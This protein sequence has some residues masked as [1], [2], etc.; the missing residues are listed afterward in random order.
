MD[1]NI[2]LDNFEGP[3]D[4]LLK[5]IDKSKI[6]IYDIPISDIT[7]QYMD[8]IYKM[9]D[10]NLELASEFLI[11]ASILL[12]IKSKMLLPLEIDLDEEEIDPREDLVLRLLAYKKYKEAARELREYETIEAQ[13]FYKPQEDLTLEEDIDYQLDFFSLHLL[14][15]SLNNILNRKNLTE[16][17]MNIGEIT[18][19]EY[20]IRECVDH[21]LEKLKLQSKIKF[22]ELL[23]EH[24]S[25]NEIVA[26]FLSV[27][28]L[29]KQKHIYVIQ[30]EA[31]TDLLI[32]KRNIE[33]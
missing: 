23:R 9:E 18:R 5:L 7:E 11:M 6:D 8:F 25:R 24:S 27:L 2:V 29:I 10:L 20:S 17:E 1:Y 4:L 32:N 16:K 12:E 15:R 19:D 22:T 21:I 33:E 13:A 31:F 26:Y 30:D 3:L 28:E 14:V